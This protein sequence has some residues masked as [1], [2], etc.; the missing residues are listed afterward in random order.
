M[1]EVS[2]G[3]GTLTY[4]TDIEMYIMYTFRK[5]SK[6]P[7]GYSI[8]EHTWHYRRAVHTHIFFS[9]TVVYRYFLT[10]AVAVLYT[11][12]CLHMREKSVAIGTSKHGS[13]SKKANDGNSIIIII[14][15]DKAKRIN[16]A[17]WCCM[18]I[19][20]KGTVYTHM[21]AL[22]TIVRWCDILKCN[23]HFE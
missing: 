6:D 9:P 11:T 18:R 20:S 15:I 19:R 16:M 13:K 10:F 4:I 12:F 21:H 8:L 7:N 17:E 3:H 2:N 1:S 5:T 14:I 23:D 22:Y